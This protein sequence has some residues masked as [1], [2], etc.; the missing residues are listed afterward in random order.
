MT[1][2]DKY[3]VLMQALF[4]NEKCN[5]LAWSKYSWAKSRTTHRSLLELVSGKYYKYNPNISDDIHLA[6]VDMTQQIHQKTI[7]KSSRFTQSVCYHYLWMVLFYSRAKKNYEFLQFVEIIRDRTKPKRLHS[8]FD[9]ITGYHQKLNV[10]RGSK[11]Q[12][13]NHRAKRQIVKYMKVLEEVNII[14]Q[15]IEKFIYN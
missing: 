7:F 9:D 12:Q 15:I 3:S 8:L 5:N 1:K 2:E 11:K 10:P 4:E 6:L 14:Y 13:K